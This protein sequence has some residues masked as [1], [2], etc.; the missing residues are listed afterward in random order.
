MA[1]RKRWLEIPTELSLERFR[2]FV[3]PHL[4]VRSRGPAPKLSFH[5][6][7]NYILKLLYLGCQWKEL[8]IERDE[9]GRREVH[10]TSVYRVF[11]RWEANGSLQ[12]VSLL[13]QAASSF[14]AVPLAVRIHE[15]LVWSNRD[16]RT[17]LDKMLALL[18]I[19][20]VEQPFYFVA[21]AYY[22]AHKIVVGLLKQNNHLL[23]RMKSN[24]VAYTAT[25]SA[26]R[27]SEAAPG[28]MAARSSSAPCGKPPATSNQPQARST[29]RAR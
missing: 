17:L 21:D 16:R 18:G 12:A 8:P 7:F 19:A 5:A 26:G 3:L 22:A 9:K 28:S 13:V 23:T 29:A 27:A 25:S 2:E 10:H 11:R 1:K 14:F 6:L 4:T 24:A 20:S 15:G